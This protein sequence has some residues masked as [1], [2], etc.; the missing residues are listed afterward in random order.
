MEVGIASHTVDVNVAPMAIDNTVVRHVVRISH[1][2]STL[3]TSH[4]VAED[5]MT[6]IVRARLCDVDTIAIM[7]RRE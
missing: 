6:A 5:T 4:H 7:R 1:V 2:L 3:A